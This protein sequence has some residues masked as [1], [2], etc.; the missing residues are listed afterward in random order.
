[1]RAPDARRGRPPRRTATGA[2]ARD[3]LRQL[4]AVA[5][6]SKLRSQDEFIQAV[7]EKLSGH[8]EIPPQEAVHAVLSVISKRVTAGEISNIKE[9]LPD[10]LQQLWPQS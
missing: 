1:M 3:L 5:Q 8:P 4:Q 6:P 2:G 10:E 7:K 9:H